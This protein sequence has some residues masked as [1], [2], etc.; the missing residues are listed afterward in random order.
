M[1]DFPN[2]MLG[3]EYKADDGN[4]YKL[5]RCPGDE[6]FLCDRCAFDDGSPVC[7]ASAPQGMCGIKGRWHYYWELMDPLYLDLR[8][9][10]EADDD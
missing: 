2:K 3:V 7:G 4:V 10:E 8:K 5:T 6:I 1:A 9:V